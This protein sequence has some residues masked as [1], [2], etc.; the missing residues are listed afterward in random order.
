[1]K[2][3][4]DCPRASSRYCWMNFASFGYSVCQKWAQTERDDCELRYRYRKLGSH[5]AISGQMIKSRSARVNATKKGE[6]PRK[7]LP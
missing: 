1:M 6:T 3:Y 4:E 2:S 5:S 7:M